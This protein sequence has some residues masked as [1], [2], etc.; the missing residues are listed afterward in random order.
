MRGTAHIMI[1]VQSDDGDISSESWQVGVPLGT[2][3]ATYLVEQLWL[4]LR[5]ARGAVR[6]FSNG[7]GTPLI[8]LLRK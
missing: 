1:A 6:S 8:G 4:A 5:P 3:S 2:A 7:P